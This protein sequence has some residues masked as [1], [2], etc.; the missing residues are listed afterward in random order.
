[1]AK[2]SA[3]SIS[4]NELR[5]KLRGQLDR[6]GSLLTD[7]QFQLTKAFA[8]ESLSYSEI[9]RRNNIS[10]QAVHESIKNTEKLLNEYDSKLAHLPS[11]ANGADNRSGG[12]NVG[13]IISRLESIKS[14][15]ARTELSYSV[16]W[17]K[18]EIDS[19][20]NL[21][22]HTESSPAVEPTTNK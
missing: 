3:V 2:L 21:L 22:D 12:R 15:I 7:K 13:E 1:M 14:K 4:R 11:P 16:D 6:F 17:I 10:R 20:M 18:R 8:I 19:V 9:A 5:L